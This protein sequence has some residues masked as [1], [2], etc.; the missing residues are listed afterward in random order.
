MLFQSKSKDSIINF[1]LI[2]KNNQKIQNVS[3]DSALTAI[4]S[5]LK[6]RESIAKNNS[7]GIAIES[8]F[9]KLGSLK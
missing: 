7:I 2:E 3:S 9:S 6:C 1:D 5:V 8:L 4:K